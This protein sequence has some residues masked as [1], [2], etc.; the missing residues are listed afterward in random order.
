[1]QQHIWI[2]KKALH[3]GIIYPVWLQFYETLEKTNLIHSDRTL[4]RGGVG[5]GS[6]DLDFGNLA[7]NKNVRVLVVV[8]IPVC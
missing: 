4:M 3:W 8:V 7:G 2:L 5:V 1:M 6:T